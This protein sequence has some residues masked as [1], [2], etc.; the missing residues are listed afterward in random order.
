MGIF[1]K[2]F[3]CGLAIILLLFVFACIIGLIF[4]EQIKNIVIRHYVHKEKRNAF[5]VAKSHS[6]Y[7]S[8]LGTIRTKIYIRI[9]FQGCRVKK[10]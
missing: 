5:T 1:C 10:S 3:L 6:Y 8:F 7:K 2:I 9:R 4:E